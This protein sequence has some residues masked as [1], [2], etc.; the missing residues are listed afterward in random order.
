METQGQLRQGYLADCVPDYL[1][2]HES[3]NSI[4][5]TKRVIVKK[6]VMPY[7]KNVYPQLGVTSVGRVLVIGFALARSV[8]LDPD[9]DPFK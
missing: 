3:G 5:T 8:T 7:L 1:L 4:E 2:S 6:R 9:S